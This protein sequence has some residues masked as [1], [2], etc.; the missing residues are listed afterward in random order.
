[1]D[2]P[3]LQ[4]VVSQAGDYAWIRFRRGE[5][6]FIASIQREGQRYMMGARVLGQT[7]ESGRGAWMGSYGGFAHLV[8]AQLAAEAWFAS[9][10]A[11][12]FQ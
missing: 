5:L 12:P 11:E 1:M 10:P 7:D 3:S 2:V 8:E 4:W 6:E 9:V